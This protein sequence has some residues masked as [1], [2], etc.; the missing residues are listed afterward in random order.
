MKTHYLYVN[1]AAYIND[2]C[3]SLTFNTGEQKLVNFSQFILNSQHPDVQKYQDVDH[4]KNFTIADGD[5]FWNDYELCF[6][7]NDLYHNRIE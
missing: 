3:L 1:D 2:Y 4:F 5:L 7:V 6:P